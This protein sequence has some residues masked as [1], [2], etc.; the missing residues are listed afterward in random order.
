MTYTLLKIFG[1]CLLAYIS[2]AYVL[3]PIFWRHYEHNPELKQ[4]PKVT[5]TNL[6]IS[7]DALNIGV[8]GTEDEV[9]NA[10]LL[11]GWLPA[12]PITFSSSR[13]IVWSV[14]A[15]KSYPTAPMSKLYLF[16]R[17]QDLAFERELGNSAK[18][19]HHVRFWQTKIL[20]PL[21][22]PL[23]IGAATFDESVGLS[24]YTGQVT[25][26]ISPDIDAER[27][28][29]LKDLQDVRQ[30]SLLYSVT[31]VGPT[32]RGRNGG[33]DSYFTDGEIWIGMISPDNVEISGQVKILDNPWPTNMI[34][35]SWDVVTHLWKQFDRES[36][37]K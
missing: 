12:D 24:H 16:K 30:V 18:R 26:R 13:K 19:R 28:K 9:I 23:W 15:Q 27:D 7:G 29:I 17:K 8:V 4:Y 1:G 20:D 31:G 11:A 37:N 36:E 5:E 33:G 2:V 34:E 35:K 14:L 22:R 32:F 3:L 6:G 25:H 21:H 10:F